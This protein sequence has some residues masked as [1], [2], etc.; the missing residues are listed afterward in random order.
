MVSAN[1]G[2]QLRQAREK[3][4]LTLK[5]VEGEIKVRG[6]FLQEFEKNSFN[7]PLP[8]VYRRGF[9][10]TYVQFLELNPEKF[11]L[12]IDGKDGE[13]RSEPRATAKKETEIVAEE[14]EGA[15]EPEKRPREGKGL[16]DI[17][18]EKLRD[19]RWQTYGGALLVLTIL[20]F[21]MLRPT[22]RRDLEWEELLGSDNAEVVLVAPNAAK[23]LSLSA[24]DEVK[25]LIRE[26]NSKQ[27]IFSGTL[28]KGSS[29]EISA[30][31]DVQISYSEGN[32]ISIR[33]EN[34]EVIRPKRPG[35]GWLEIPY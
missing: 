34:G 6:D 5:Q 15:A 30:R 33:R 20:G 29:E 1:L 28:K 10:K 16:R 12:Q 22:P 25:V 24:T 26:K 11:L 32:A 2:E 31:E 7:F 9:L 17:I 35:A 4:Q 18:L 3:R 27:K 19:R 13:E 23:K 21:F 8:A 14:E